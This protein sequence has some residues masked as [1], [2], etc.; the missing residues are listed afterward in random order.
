MHLNIVKIAGVLTIVTSVVSLVIAAI[1]V[2]TTGL[3]NIEK[4]LGL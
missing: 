3:A 4:D 2:R 1:W